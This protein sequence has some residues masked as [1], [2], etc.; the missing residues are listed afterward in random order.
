[1]STPLNKTVTRESTVI[2]GDKNII[3]SITENQTIEIKLKGAKFGPV[4][5]SIEDLYKQLTG[6]N[7]IKPEGPV[8]IK[9]KESKDDSNQPLINLHDFRSQ[10]LIS[11]EIPLEYKVKLEQIT[12]SLI[13]EK[14]KK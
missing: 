6:G 11:S 8:V 2:V 10:Y 5:I 4:E 9:H 1:M 12:V 7:L 3:I 14:L 13:K